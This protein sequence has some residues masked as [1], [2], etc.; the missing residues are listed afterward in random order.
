M[1]GGRKLIEVALPLDVINKESAREKQPFTAHH[2]RSLHV[3]WARRPLVACRAVLFAQL[4]D[5]PSAHPDLFP[6]EGAQTSERERLFELIERLVKWEN[7]SNETILEEARAEIRKSCGDDLPLILDPFAGGGSIPIEAQRLGLQVYASDL[8]PVAVLINKALI[9][10]PPQWAGRPAVRPADP[11]RLR[12]DVADG[13]CGLAEDVRYYGQWIFDQ[14][15]DRMGQNYPRSDLPDGGQADTI[16]WIWSRI[17]TCPNPA[18][19]GDAPLVRSFWLRKKANSSTWVVPIVEGRKVRFDIASGKSGPTVEGTVE[20]SGATCLIC[21]QPIHFK[22]VRGE[23]RAGRIGSQLMTIVAEGNRQRVFLP[24]NEDH[25]RASQ[26]EI[27]G[28]APESELPEQ[29]LG[30]R[31]QAYGMTHH[32]DLFTPRQLQCMMVLS[33]LVGEART[34]VK[35]DAVAAGLPVGEAETYADSIA[36]YLAMAVARWS[37]LSNS[38]CSWNSTN[39][40]IRAL[41]ARQAIPM[42]WDYAEMNLLRREG[43]ISAVFEMAA[44]SVEAVPA[45]GSGHTVRQEDAQSIAVEAVV[46]TDPPYYDNI[47]YADLADFFYVWLRRSLQTVYPSLFSTLLT[48]KTEELVATPY[49]FDGSRAK[50]EQHF[51][52]GLINAFKAIRRGQLAD[53]PMTVFYAF[54]QTETDTTD[55]STTSTGWETMLEGLIEA[56]LM[57]TATWPVRT[58][59][60]ARSVG[61]GTNALASSIVLVCRL[62]PVEAGMTDRRGF[63]EILRSEL[64]T[65]LREM[66][67]GSIAPVDLAQASIGPGMAVF[68]RFARVLEP[69]GE[70]MRVKSALALINQVLDEVLTEQEGDFDPTTRWAIKWFTQFGFDQGPFGDAETL[71]KATGT[72]INGMER[73]GILASRAS[74]VWLLSRS[75]LR[76]DWDPANDDRVP[77]WEATQY[78][79]K[80]LDEGGEGAAAELLAKLG[81]VGETARDLAYRLYSTCEAEK[82]A[83]EAGFYNSLVTSWPE[84]RR[85]ATRGTPGQGSLINSGE[86]MALSNR[87]RVGRG[88]EL[89]A[90]GMKPFVDR[91]MKAT[92]DAKERW[93][94][95]W[96]KGEQAGR[97][98]SFKVSLDDP[99]V[100]LNV[101]KA[102]WKQTFERDLSNQDRNAAYDLANYRNQW[103]HNDAFSFD[104]C[105]RVLDKIEQLLLAIDSTQAEDAGQAK[106]DLMRVKFEQETKKRAPTQEALISEPAAGLKP[107]R[108]V[109]EPHDD[110]ARGKF[111]LAEFAAD[112]HQVSERR[113]ASEYTDPVEFFRRTYLTTGLRTLLSQAVGRLGGEGGVPVVDLQT[114]FGGGKTHSMIALYHLFSGIPLAEFPEEIRELVRECGVDELPSVARAV[115]VGTKLSPGQIDTKPDGTEVHTLWGELAWQLGGPEAYSLIAES[116][117]KGTSPGKK[118]GDLFRLVGP[119]LVLIDEWVAYAR[120]LFERSDLGAGSFDTQFSFAQTIT[121]EVTS[122]NADGS[123]LNAML[124]VSLPASEVIGDADTGLGSEVEVGGAAGRE[125]L[126]RLHNV[127]SRKEN[128]WRPADVAESYEIVRRRLFKEFSPEALKDRDATAAAMGQFYARQKAE[129][130]NECSQAEYVT[131]IKDA[132]PIHPELFERLYRDWSTLERFQRTRGVLRLMAAVIHALWI[133]GD[134]APVILP[135]SVPL[136]DPAVAAELTRNLEDNWKPIID[137]DIDGEDSQP[138]A[139]DKDFPNLGKYSAARRTARAVFLGS[140]P[141]LRT[142]N[143]GTD[144]ARVRLASALP[145]ETVATFGDALEK[146]SDRC[147]YLYRDGAR[148]WYGTQE[149]VTR[150]ARDEA[151][152]LLVQAR[153]EI[154]AEIVRRLDQVVRDRGSFVGVHIAPPN[155][156]DV[157]DDAECRLVILGPDRPHITKSDD[158]AALRAA[159]SILDERGNAARVYRNMLVMLAPDQRRL[160]ELEAGVADHLAWTLIWDERERRNLDPHQQHQAKSKL[161]EANRV[162]ALRI[163]ETYIWGLFPT[164]PDANG[165]IGWSTLKCDGQGDLPARVSKKLGNEGV[166]YGEYAASLLRMQLDG[167]LAPRWADGHVAVGALWDDFARYVYLPRLP[168]ISTLLDTVRAGPGSLTWESDGF[169]TADAIE[170]GIYRGL[171]RAQHATVVTAQT[172]VVRPDR[173]KQQTESADGTGTGTDGEEEAEGTGSDGDSGGT[174]PPG[175]TAPTRF[176]GS[177]VL[178]PLRLNRDFGKIADEVVSHLS[179]LVGADVKITVEIEATANDGFPD[180]TVRTVSENAKTLKFDA[181]GFEQR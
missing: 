151:E 18:C 74:K 8:N 64:P 55:G 110:V 3:W 40:S 94:E 127:V 115:I 134:Q 19:G 108:A 120:Q 26:V 71:C 75:D 66:Q 13:A 175:V 149:S 87:D 145:G 114:N 50:A 161:E 49:R 35:G 27:T 16:A 4:V 166:L 100:Q 21:N 61:L 137:S 125:A 152:R 116:D 143:V 141:T 96:V 62:R 106:T 84:I 155:A 76:D 11:S 118:L 171:T 146:L 130:P 85:K 47:G 98:G 44:T 57:V 37:D 78:L 132:Y 90:A 97:G 79:V 128:P 91:R 92:H 107:W 122:T 148:Y 28:D 159:K 29:A 51:Q 10:I 172:L 112:L 25:I 164:Q 7:S 177:A 180:G 14:A 67:Q 119:C 121:E 56:E 83:K 60:A 65:A 63:L 135:A 20:R 174:S 39:E 113:G 133:R 153:A 124:V 22:Y 32:A 46:S 31:V 42:A 77:V 150:R 81:G 109:V 140:A 163:A 36:T 144:A 102:N 68:S 173:A 86:T 104:D 41:F 138:A 52:H 70:Q 80:A 54:K 24:P 154:H 136:D 30:F 156:S 9:E 176:Y 73:S 88:F 158:T 131:R 53:F 147:T 123:S 5:D 6:T 181:H 95:A 157:P 160:E 12:L 82:W 1:S 89:L 58:E 93:F 2:P 167:V 111:A 34:H 43:G 165:P 69:S 126:K 23:G 103:A 17:V 105:Y 48:P 179:G 38:I 99:L 129:F 72:A 168:S 45:R 33:D 139:I 170:D 117:R 142:A 178:D 162:V 15:M 169:A 59:R 101:I